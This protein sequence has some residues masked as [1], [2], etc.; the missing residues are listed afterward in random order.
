MEREAEKQDSVPMI[1]RGTGNSGVLFL[2]AIRALRAMR[3]KS[4]NEPTATDAMICTVFAVAAIET[5]LYELGEQALSELEKSPEGQVLHGLGKLVRDMEGSKFQPYQ[6]V[7]W[8]VRYLTGKP[9]DQGTKV[10]QDFDVL[11]RLRNLIIHLK[12]TE[13]I[14]WYQDGS[15]KNVGTPK[16]ISQLESMGLIP[17]PYRPSWV[18]A[19]S[20]AEIAEWSCLTARAMVE[21]LTNLLPDSICKHL[22][23]NSLTA[24][25]LYKPPE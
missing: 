24:F 8:I 2:I 1:G 15:M 22:T 5:F 9:A 20:T 13:E 25:R 3:L 18:V 16:V 14:W 19:I 23:A 10:F 11:V 17:K 7:I 4:K 6:K 21:T 12:D